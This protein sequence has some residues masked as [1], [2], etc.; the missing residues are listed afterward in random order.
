MNLDLW[1]QR[2]GV[3][4]EAINELKQA[5]GTHDTG[6]PL[7]TAEDKAGESAAQV[8][9]RLEASKKNCR[10]WRNNNGATY[11][12]DGRFIR[13]G[14][15]NDSKAINDRIK[16][17][18]LIGVR[19]VLI[20]PYHVGH[21]FGQFLAREIKPPGWRYTGKERERAQLNFLELVMSLG[22]DAS[23]ATGVGTI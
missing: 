17:S 20:E 11:A 15:A 6:Q 21:T 8:E 9:V 23:F 16:S 10:L 5:F 19:P 2:W 13:Y 7:T 3:P 12:E 22:G 14:L 18:D 1:A 4:D